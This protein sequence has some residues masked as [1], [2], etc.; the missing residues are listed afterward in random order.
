VKIYS[1]RAVL[2]SL[3]GAEEILLSFQG[4]RTIVEH[5]RQTFADASEKKA[6]GVIGGCLDGKRVSVLRAVPLK[7]N[8]R[9][10]PRFRAALDWIEEEVIPVAGLPRSNRGWVAAPEEIREVDRILDENGL[11]LL[12]SYHMHTVA[13]SVCTDFDKH[14]ARDSQ[15]WTIIVAHIEEAFPSVRAFYEGQCEREASV[16][17][18]T[19]R[20]EYSS[21]I[22]QQHR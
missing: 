5:C 19:R 14:L 17:C 20:V 11:M 7:R 22:S 16:L 6:F 13:G 3:E 21:D 9:Q 12:G 4:Y 18:E 10:D 2:P 15:L 8:L 1:N